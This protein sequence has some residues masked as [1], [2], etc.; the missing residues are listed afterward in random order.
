M[1]VTFSTGAAREP[2]VER[3]LHAL[4]LGWFG[5]RSSVASTAMPTPA[6]T[7]TNPF[8]MSHLNYWHLVEFDFAAVQVCSG[9][10]PRRSWPSLQIL[11]IH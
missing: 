1:P 2:A 4:G 11:K 8:L 5:S 9:E 3:R 6:K 7:A 10:K